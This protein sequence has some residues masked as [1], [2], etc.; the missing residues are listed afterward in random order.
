M[1]SACNGASKPRKI[2]ELSGILWAFSAPLHALGIPPQLR[3]TQESGPGNNEEKV[4]EDRKF[5]TSGG[6]R[7]R[8]AAAARPPLALDMNT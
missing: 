3:A 8:P 4:S 2:N 7:Q 5:G 1:P 6:T